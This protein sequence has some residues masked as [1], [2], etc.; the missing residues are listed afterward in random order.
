MVSVSE[1]LDLRGNPCPGNLPK[2]LLTLEGLDEGD[3]LEIILDDI[4]ALDRIPEAIREE[5][6]YK[7]LEPTINGHN[8]HL[9]I[10]VY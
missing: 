10:K 7:M 5:P 3:I 4:I 2:I 6:D 9:F 8:I 1:I